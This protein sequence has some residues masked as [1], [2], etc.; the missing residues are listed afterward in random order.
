MKI[1]QTQLIT[2][3]TLVSMIVTGTL[4]IESRY[5]KHNRVAKASLLAEEKL[6]EHEIT[7]KEHALYYYN[8]Q[9]VLS[10]KERSR[11]DYLEKQL[12][13]KYDAKEAV[14]SAL[15]EISKESD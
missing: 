8:S 3:F 15:R 1:T 2:T 11:A 14:D 7:E 6:L 10:P 5:A 12:S 13:R 4:F 9:E